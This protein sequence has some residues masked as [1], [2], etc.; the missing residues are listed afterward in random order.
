MKYYVVAEL[1]ISDEGWVLSYLKEVTKMVEQH[2]GRYLV[3]TPKIEKIEGDRQVPQIF[4][5]IEFPSKEAAMTFY[6][7]AEYQPYLKARMEGGSTEML[8]V[9]GED[10]ANKESA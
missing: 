4:I 5:I 7:S 8:L 1:N 6:S 10:I 3:R 2:G 9:A